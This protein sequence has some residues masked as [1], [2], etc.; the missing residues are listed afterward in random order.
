ML[1]QWDTQDPTEIDRLVYLL[2]EHHLEQTRS[3]KSNTEYYPFENPDNWLYPYE[4]LSWLRIREL[5]GLENPK[6]FTHPLMNTEIAQFFL[7]LDIPLKKPKEVPYARELLERLQAI[8]PEV[9]IPSW[10]S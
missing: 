9:E 1:K 10:L 4:I 3:A 7:T 8:C 5:K 6:T 2:A